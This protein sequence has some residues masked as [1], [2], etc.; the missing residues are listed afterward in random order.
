MHYRWLV[1]AFT[2]LMQ[3]VSYG[4]LVYSFALFVV[5]WLTTFEAERAGV[6]MTVF[7][8]QIGMGVISPFAGR[9]LDQYPSHW[10]VTGGGLL[11][12]TGLLLVS[13]SS[14]LWQVTL[15]YALLLPV[16]ITLTGPLAAQTIIT[17]WFQ[18]QRGLAIGVSAVGTSL[19]GFLLPILT[20]MLL[21][22][23][24]WRSVLQYLAILSLLLI[25]PLAW[26]IL[27]RRIPTEPTRAAVAAEPGA[28]TEPVIPS[29][30]LKDWT[31][32][33]ILTTR[34]FW[35]PVLAL[36]PLSMAFGGVQFNLA[37][38]AQDLGN[39]VGQAAW[40]IS[41]LS[42]AMI[43]GKLFF[44]FMADRVEHRNLYWLAATFMCF[45][46][47]GL[48]GEPSY[49]ILALCSISMG[50][51]VGG[52]LPLM[53]AI[54]SHRFGAKSF[55]RVMGLVTMIITIGGFGPLIAGA[56]FDATGNYDAAFILFLAVLI[57]AAL[58]M[59]GL[60]K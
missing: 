37:A 20:S 26:L 41:V 55:G 27:R 25:C 19:G 53:G 49:T 39:T 34:N 31:T 40:L 1:V 35:L 7:V 59:L 24:E 43:V 60:K 12:A 38:Y 17:K 33:E 11:L 21:V 52:L 10:L 54:Y 13:I 18:H 4:I 16:A 30:E 15:I 46:L 9:L 14:S 56:V 50:L 42:L 44:G 23:M 47:I 29:H 45:T 2:M 58:G 28:A 57:P 8:L 36:L 6:M 3:A 5:P 22:G 48:Q 51:A 32:R